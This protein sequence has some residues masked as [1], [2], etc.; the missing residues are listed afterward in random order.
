MLFKI[1]QSLKTQNNKFG[2]LWTYKYGKI[3]SLLIHMNSGNI[4]DYSS[5]DNS[6]LVQFHLFISFLFPLQKKKETIK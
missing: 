3:F 2:D 6:G 4:S 5:R 1:D